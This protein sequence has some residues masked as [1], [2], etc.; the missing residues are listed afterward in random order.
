M[1][2]SLDM[3]KGI[4]GTHFIVHLITPILWNKK[5][6]MFLKNDLINGSN[7][8][9]NI[10]SEKNYSES[11]PSISSDKSVILH[12]ILKYKLVLNNQLLKF[13]KLLTT[14]SR[15]GSSSITKNFWTTSWTKYFSRRWLMQIR[16][17]QR[18]EPCKTQ[19]LL[20]DRDMGNQGIVKAD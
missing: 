4:K 12:N 3:L 11:Q 19:R 13:H 15:L 18:K 7:Q 10:V 16:R 2:I 14:S 6:A 9:T 8:I 17:R 1:G 5:N 20:E